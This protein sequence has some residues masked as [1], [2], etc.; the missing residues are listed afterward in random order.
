MMYQEL[1]LMGNISECNAVSKHTLYYILG[2]KIS[3]FLKRYSS[4]TGIKDRKCQT[5]SILNMTQKGKGEMPL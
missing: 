5:Q 2:G 3:L 1:P 4:N